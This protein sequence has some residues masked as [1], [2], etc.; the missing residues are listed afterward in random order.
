MT[1]RTDA[2]HRYV[3]EELVSELGGLSIDICELGENLCAIAAK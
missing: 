2:A 3:A 1:C